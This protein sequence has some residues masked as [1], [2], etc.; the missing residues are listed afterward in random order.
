MGAWG[1]SQGGGLTLAATALSGRFALAMPDVPYLC[2][3]RRALEIAQQGPYLELANYFKL[4]PEREEP[5]FRTLSYFDNMNLADRI[6]CPVLMTVGLVDLVCPP[7][8]IYATYNRIEAQKQMAIN[9]TTRMRCRRQHVT[10]QI[11]WANRYL[12]GLNV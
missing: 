9:P 3:Y 7:S 12:R 6:T 10:E 1:G 5:S 8:S 11:R 2:H 4:Y